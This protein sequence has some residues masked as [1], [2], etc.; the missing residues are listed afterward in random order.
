ME[1][2][3]IDE[4]G[5]H[6][7]GS[8]FRNIPPGSLVEKALL[9]KEGR[10]SK[11]GCLCIETG[12]RTGRSPNDKYIVDTPAV[13]DKIAWGKVNKPVSVEK[14]DK[15]YQQVVK[16]FEDKDLYIFDGFA[17]ANPKYSYAFRIINE[18]ASQNLFISNLLIKPTARELQH[19]Q[20]DFLIL[21]APDCKVDASVGLNSDVAV[22]IDYERHIV[23]IAGTGYSGEI[24]KSVFC[25]MNY[26]LP[27][28][29]VFTMHCSAN[30]GDDGNTA[31]FFG[32][33]GTGKTTLSA[34]P[35]RKLIGDDE[36]GWSRTSIFNFEGGCYAKCIRLSKKNEPEIWNA[37]RFGAVAEN[38]CLFEDTRVIDF[39]DDSITENTRVGYPLNFIP[40]IEASG[41]GPIPKTI[42]FLA[43]DAFGVLPP[44]SKLDKN[45]AAYHFVSGYTS[46]LA[47]TEDGITEPQA[48]F[49]TCFGEPFLP[50]DPLLYAKQ[51]QRRVEKAGAS[52]FLINTGWVGGAYGVGKRI[53]LKYTR[54]MINA[55]INGDL[56]YVSY[57]TDPF[58]NLNMPKFCP[59]VPQELLNPRA[60]WLNKEDYDKTAMSLVKMFQDNFKQYTNFPETVINAGP[61]K[62]K[63]K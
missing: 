59:G 51:F 15:V 23:L 28:K 5:I 57:E 54:A 29:N 1:N 8:I 50:L 61:G 43:A 14:F 16:H 33:S 2:Y 42:F 19:F 52:V 32:L 9:K 45:S 13:H 62:P 53:P 35:N 49:S 20:E 22:M 36:H 17:G 46:K 27:Q 18:K 58:F 4:Y 10:L 37:V 41:V 25:V 12:E 56:D 47:G 24:K 7:T 26:M 40:N 11:A 55:A 6:T 21:V 30:I 60:T 31:L 38:V 44:I 63:E 48:T 39:N 34:D 3:G